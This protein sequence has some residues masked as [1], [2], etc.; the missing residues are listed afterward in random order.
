MTSFHPR[1]LTGKV[2]K[3]RTH[4][5]AIGGHADIWMGEWL[6]G[7]PSGILL[8]S[9]VSYFSATPLAIKVMRDVRCDAVYFRRL[10][11]VNFKD[12]IYTY[13]ILTHL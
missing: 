9:P 13:S 10:K 11:M 12:I 5:F 6:Q 8:Q 3:I 7:L 2:R 4:P 1:D